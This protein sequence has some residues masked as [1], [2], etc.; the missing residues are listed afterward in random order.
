M[1]TDKLAM[2]KADK[3]DKSD[4]KLFELGDELKRLRN[5]KADLE[6]QAKEVNAK[7]DETDQLLS[8]LMINTE[9]QNFTRSGTMFC[10]T[11]KTRAS[12]AAGNKETLFKVLKDNGYSALIYETVNANSLSSFINEQIEENNDTLPA[13]LEGLVNVYDKTTVSVRKATRKQ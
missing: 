5:L 3:S 1:E 8:E 10:L 7:I 6:D 11:S 4:N 12:A 13:W 9:T 2:D